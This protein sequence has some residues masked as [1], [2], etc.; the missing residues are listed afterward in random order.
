MYEAVRDAPRSSRPSYPPTS[1]QPS[2][3]TPASRNSRPRSHSL[4]TSSRSDGS[5]SGPLPLMLSQV[6]ASLT[7]LTGHTHK[8][9]CG[10]PHTSRENNTAENGPPRVPAYEK[11]RM[12]TR[13]GL[14]AAAPFANRS[15]LCVFF[16]FSVCQVLPCCCCIL[17]LVMEFEDMLF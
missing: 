7:F 12:R 4:L 9:D 5:T 3:A 8:R 14:P 15:F 13:D 2:T 1:Q 6:A 11:R 17:T 10:P 16:R